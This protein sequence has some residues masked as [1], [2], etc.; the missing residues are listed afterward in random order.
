MRFLRALFLFVPLALLMGV[1]AWVFNDAEKRA[2]T[3]ARRRFAAQTEQ[4]ALTLLNSGA[5]RSMHRPKGLRMAGYVRELKYGYNLIDGT[6]SVWVEDRPGH[7]IYD[8]F[9]GSMIPVRT[10][11]RW[12]SLVLLLAMAAALWFSVRSFRRDTELRDEFLAAASH[13]LMTPLVCL[14]FGYDKAQVERLIRLVD[15]INDF[16]KLGGRRPPPR[17]SVFPIGR[18]IEAAY[19]IFRSQYAEEESGEVEMSGGLETKVFADE[20][21][22]VQILWNLFGNELKYAAPFG[23]V[24]LE[25]KVQAGKVSVIFRDEGPGMS[26]WQR[27]NC[28]RR[29]YRARTALESGKGG[30]GIGLCTAREMAHAMHGRLA[31]RSVR[32]HGCEFALTLPAPRPG[33]SPHAT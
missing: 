19:S 24:R 13:D 30:F 29:Y 21:L 33:N 7:I 15:N 6:P 27:V 23:K 28:F 2:E 9:A 17:P 4:A 26:W 31:V 5:A 11:A 10:I 3:W 1:S 22:T 16:L 8:D 32:P 25:T 14:R 20:T 18:A 12:G